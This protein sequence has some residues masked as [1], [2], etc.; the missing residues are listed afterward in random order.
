MNIDYSKDGKVQCSFLGMAI[1][2]KLSRFRFI[3]LPSP[4]YLGNREPIGSRKLVT[5]KCVGKPGTII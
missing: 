5:S 4:I 1:F 2:V 3:L